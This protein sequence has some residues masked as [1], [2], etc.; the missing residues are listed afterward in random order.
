M[1]SARRKIAKA[2][3]LL[4]GLQVLTQLSGLMKQVLIAAEFGT[5][6]T[7][8]GYL[9]ATAVVGLIMLWIRLPINQTLIP[10]F[11]YDLARRGE[12]AAWANFSVLFNNLVLVL[13]VV[14]ATGWLLAPYLV[15]LISPG[16]EATT[17]I[18]ATSLARI[19]II[20]V[21][22]AGLGGV[23]SQIY[24]SYE[25]F[26][27]PGITG[28]VNNI[29]VMLIL[30]ALSSLYGIHGLAI[31]VVLGGASQ[32]VIKLP[33]LWKKSKLLS[34]KVNLRHPGMIEMGKL[35]FPLLFSTGGAQLGRITDRIF[36]S[37]LSA[38]SLSALAYGHRLITIPFEFLIR[39]LQKSTYPHFTK[40]TAEENFKSLSRQL[41]HY[42]RLVFLITVP[43]AIG[44]MLVPAS[45]VSVLYQRGAFDEMSTHLTS[46]ALFF[47]AMGFPA[48]ALARVLNRTFF[49]LKDT[50]TPTKISLLR[51]GIKIA[52]SWI[53]IR[54]LAHRGIALAE[55]ISQMTRAVFLFFLLPQR[56][57]GKE[58]WNT[59][60][61]FGLT[62]AGSI[63][64]IFVVYPVKG[65]IN[66]LFSL[67]SGLLTLGLLGMATYGVMT[68]LFQREELETL[69]GAFTSL[70]PK[71]FPKQS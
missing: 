70:K 6:E 34:R 38:G 36:A 30:L 10:M 19:T 48:L 43:V 53:L 26:F 12:E 27:L 51:I 5:S 8:D 71:P 29:V 25:S 49:S 69:I 37:L 63:S 14:A 2:A 50:W 66:E 62:L 56:V 1:K 47:Y 59:V 40:L 60:K 24:F 15:A 9:V 52:L 21:F 58:L 44:I 67:P 33:I 20:G 11:R 31:A 42:L 3:T 64:M 55:S 32:F 16:F 39:P 13:T 4:L 18:L 7:M 54:P 35:S 46:Q 45:I 23:L 61:S 22:F 68:F 57:K 41:F 65:Q 28:S 17:G